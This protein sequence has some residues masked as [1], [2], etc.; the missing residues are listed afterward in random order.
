MVTTK[1]FE[2]NTASPGK[3]EKSVLIIYTGGTMGMV[4]QPDGSLG[5]FDFSLIMDNI[6]SLALLQIRLG[7][8]AFENPIDSSN[9][10]PAYWV[11]IGKIIK[12]AYDSYDGFVILHG[13]DTMAYT[14][15]ALSFMLEGL[16]KPIVFTGAQLPLIATRT[17]AREN[18]VT[19]IEIASA[20]VD[21]KPVISEVTILFNHVLLRANRCKKVESVYFDAFQSEN[22]P[23]LAEAGVSIDYRH[24]NIQK[25][26]ADQPFHLQEQMDA[27]VGLLKLF[28]GM[29]HDYAATVLSTPGLKAL[30]MESFGAGNAP[31]DEAFIELLRQSI[32]KGIIIFNVSQCNGGRVM[33]GRY[34]TSILLKK[35]GVISGR[36]ITTEAALAKL[37]YLLGKYQ[38]IDQ[39]KKYLEI[40]IRGEMTDFT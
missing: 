27:S 20:R 36:D 19:A 35:I 9:V 18:L 31:T 4:K 8:V 38:D 22:F 14:A 28:P 10:N 2:I 12:E 5:P 3:A 25:S 7:V 17:D 29:P 24:N 11:E 37:M 1:K 13:T 40:S 26:R 6:P 32:E 15:S 30:V 34:A 33:Q 23:A 16:S 39:A 21:E